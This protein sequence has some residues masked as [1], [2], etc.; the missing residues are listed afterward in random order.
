M[1]YLTNFIVYTLAMVG[2]IMLALFVYKGTSCNT[3]K[4]TKF[5]KVLDTM[6]IGPR[7][8]LYI[9]AAGQEKFLIAGDVDRTTLISKLS[10]VQNYE[11]KIPAIVT[12][13]NT[14][15]PTQSF[16]ETMSMQPL[17]ND[18]TDKSDLKYQTKSSVSDTPYTAVLKNLAV[19]M[20]ESNNREKV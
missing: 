15:F 2:V 20:R 1:G 14:N 6:S 4:Q 19:K 13:D 16:K 17:K 8:N 11:D 7:K 3:K 10:P 5:L 9:V 12:D 18:Y